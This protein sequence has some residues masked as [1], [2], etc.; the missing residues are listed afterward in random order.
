[1]YRLILAGALALTT[2]CAMPGPS[3]PSRQG[4]NLS[5]AREAVRNCDHVADEGGRSRVAGNYVGGV[6][7]GGLILGPVVVAA[8]EGTIR[9]RGEA[10][11][12]D[13]CLAEQ[14]FERRDLT[15]EE[16]GALRRSTPEGRRALLDHLVG[17]GTLDSFGGA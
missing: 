16:V 12:V 7:L 13:R 9:A 14:G 17:G 5:A 6:L 10:A 2:G 3:V 8:N 4:E 1:M 11:A 15:P